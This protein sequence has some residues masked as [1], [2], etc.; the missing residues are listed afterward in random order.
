M[1]NDIVLIPVLQVAHDAKCFG[2]LYTRVFIDNY[3]TN[4]FFHKNDN[5]WVV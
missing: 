5:V 1:R 4:L 2:L 3:P